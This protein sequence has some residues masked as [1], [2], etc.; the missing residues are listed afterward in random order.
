MAVPI[1]AEALVR[2][3]HAAGPFWPY[4]C[5]APFL[6]TGDGEM[7]AR[8]ARTSYQRA[9]CGRVGASFGRH[10][11][12]RT[13]K[14]IALADRLSQVSEALVNGAPRDPRGL[15][16]SRARGR[17]SGGGGCSVLLLDLPAEPLLAAA[18]I[19]VE[20]GWY[21]VPVIQRWIASPA[22]LPC[23]RLVERLIAGAQRAR[24]PRQTRTPRGVCGPAQ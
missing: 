14:D 13:R 4:V 16:L 7:L 9:S 2:W 1:L 11:R 17:G 12:R 6:E 18:P 10:T 20:R 3:Q 8:E 19:L 15:P 5:A 21:V 23:R 22:I 24:R